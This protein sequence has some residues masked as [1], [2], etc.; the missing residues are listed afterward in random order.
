MLRTFR[1]TAAVAFYV[2][3]ASFFV[4]AVLFRN[5]VGGNWPA[6]W[7]QVADLP[8][9]LSA[10]LYAGISLYQSVRPAEGKARMLA[11]AVAAPLTAFFLLLLALNFWPS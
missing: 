7:M 8:L 2:L 9:A 3:G 6:W 5:G 10:V 4:A 1:A 11:V